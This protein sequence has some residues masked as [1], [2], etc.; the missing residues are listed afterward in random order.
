MKHT[1]LKYETYSAKI[2]DHKVL[3][4]ETHKVLKYDI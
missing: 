1:A 2:G 4:Y 3:K